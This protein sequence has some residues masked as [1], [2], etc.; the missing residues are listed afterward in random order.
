MKKLVP[1]LLAMVISSPVLAAQ[2]L[3]LLVGI[4]NYA[5]RPL[6]GPP[7][8]V[9]AMRTMLTQR[10]GFAMT[11][12]KILTNQE[13]TRANILAGLD[14]LG[15]RA[16]SGD[17]VLFY[18]SGHGVSA[19][20]SGNA[21]QGISLPQS[22][23]ALVPYDAVATPRDGNVIQASKLIV[24]RDD[25]RPRLD[26][27][28][29]LGA[30]TLVI[31][32]ACYSGQA[33]RS[34]DR[35]EQ[36][37]GSLPKRFI[38]ESFND[39]GTQ[40]KVVDMTA[41][42]A[43]G[44]I[45]P[46]P[47]KN[48]V[49]LAAAAQGETA[50]DIDQNNIALLPTFDKRPHGAMTDALLRVMGNQL[51]AD[52]NGDGRLSYS[53]LQ[54]AVTGFMADRGYGHSPQLL[55]PIAEDNQGLTTRGVLGTGKLVSGEALRKPSAAST[56]L[57]I[58]APYIKNSAAVSAIDRISGIQRV[59]DVTA[60][61]LRLGEVS[62]RFELRTQSNDLLTTIAT[63]DIPRLTSVLAG[64]SAAHRLRSLA[65]QGQ[66]AV[67]PFASNPADFGGNFLFGQNVNFVVRPDRAATL[68]VL[69]LD[70]NGKWSTLYPN[71]KSEQ[72]ALS[73]NTARYIPG[74]SQ[75]MMIDVT[76][77]EGQDTVFAFAFDAPPPGLDAITGLVTVDL[78]D[79]R[80]E[81]FT[82]GLA[83]Q[84]GRYTFAR[85]ELRAFP[86]PNKTAQTKP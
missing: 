40:T 52:A 53:E 56:S 12:V 44:R 76:A 26:K 6:D 59:S 60:G 83:K 2:N 13:A 36:G 25:L 54:F 48:V 62:G 20:D 7:N 82:A 1:A 11:D 70:A 3:A 9:D 5:V 86:P 17:N 23:G 33:V 4:G 45:D 37:V 55:P 78:Q 28:D 27:L 75:H 41:A 49:F 15:R 18:Y 16:K 46:Y 51:G 30:N 69:N 67:L 29:A 74:E 42:V 38:A 81:R 77:P 35:P 84:A 50:L 10:W 47:Y 24:G 63:G 58:A 43:P 66:R 61:D 73:A 34:L 72:T 71:T 31:A 65:Q 39:A 14:D 68:V 79:P 85:V 19:L 57:R 22:S 64:Y 21:S 8:D 32:D 80:M